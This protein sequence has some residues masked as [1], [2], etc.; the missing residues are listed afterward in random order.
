MTTMWSPSTSW[1]NTSLEDRMLTLVRLGSLTMS[2]NSRM[3]P[4]GSGRS[5]VWRDLSGLSS[6]PSKMMPPWVLA[7]AE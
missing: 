2:Q 6:T 4:S 1:T 3:S 7:K 5:T